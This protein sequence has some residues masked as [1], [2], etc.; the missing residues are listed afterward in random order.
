MP[1]PVESIVQGGGQEL[2]EHQGL[3]EGF[4][5]PLDKLLGEGIYAD[6]QVQAEYDGDILS[7]CRK[8]ALNAWDKVREP[9]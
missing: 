7:L 4:E 6:P 3:K 9:G 1:N 2:L 5:A 8:A